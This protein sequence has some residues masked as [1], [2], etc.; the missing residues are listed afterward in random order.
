MSN[1]DTQFESIVGNFDPPLVDQAN[2]I[3]AHRKAEF[4]R[5]GT[6]A[7]ILTWLALVIPVAI[8]VWKAA[9]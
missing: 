5:M 3:L 8:L 6:S 2:A 4:I 1:E 9:L 7:L